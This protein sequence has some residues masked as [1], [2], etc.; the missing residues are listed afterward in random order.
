M[1]GKRVFPRSQTV[2]IYMKRLVAISLISTLALGIVNAD[3][4]VA[5]PSSKSKSSRA[6]ALRAG[7]KKTGAEVSLLGISLYDSGAL[8]V[9]KFGSP[10]E[11]QALTI[12]TASDSGGGGGAG[13]GRGPG[14]G[15]GGSNSQR[16]METISPEDGSDFIGDPFNEG[17]E[18]R[19][20]GAPEDEARGGGSGSRR[21]GPGGE[22]A[23]SPGGPGG[24][25][26]SDAGTAEDANFTRWVYRNKGSRYGFVLDKYNKVIQIEAVGLTDSRVRTKR[27][28]EFGDTFQTLIQQYGDPDGY[29]ISG[30]HIVVR[31]MKKARVA[32]RITRLKPNAKHEVTGVV[33]AAGKK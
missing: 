19:Q 32:F 2:Q 7:A 33:V 30:D 8:V 24:D 28:V 18:L 29:E 14:G 9:K 20:S 27:G 22:G 21:F 16:A 31:F 23:G 10:D 26:G 12:G 17:R 1:I 3:G 11:I 25:S 13:S 4:G 6:A 15:G 5:Y